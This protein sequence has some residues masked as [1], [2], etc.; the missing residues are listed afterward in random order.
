MLGSGAIGCS[1]VNNYVDSTAMSGIISEYGSAEKVH[2]IKGNIVRNAGGI[3]IDVIDYGGVVV[4]GNIVEE[5]QHSGIYIGTAN[6]V[7][8]N[9]ICRNNGQSE[10]ATYMGRDGIRI[11]DATDVVVTGNRCYDDQTTKTQEYGIIE[12]GTSDYNL[13]VGN[14][15]R[16]NSVGGI[17]TVG[18][19]TISA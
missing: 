7:V 14:N 3:G 11:Y 10:E 8:T 1:V 16:G 18:T 19:N 6:V 4:D 9:N 15:C 2:I 5:S 17:S 12:V 13:I